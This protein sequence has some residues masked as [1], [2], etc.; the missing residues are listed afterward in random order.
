[1][2]LAEGI[3]NLLII[4]RQPMALLGLTHA[5]ELLLL[6][7]LFGRSRMASPRP[8]STA[9]RLMMAVWLGYVGDPPGP[10][11][12]FPA[13]GRLDCPRWTWPCIRP[14]RR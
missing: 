11:L 8:V 7:G 6:G 14:S 5:A 2:L 9:E 10:R 4:A 12:A 3:V 13:C 1:M